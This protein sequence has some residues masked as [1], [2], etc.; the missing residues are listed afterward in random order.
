V[1]D[2]FLD[3][4]AGPKLLESI[5][6]VKSAGSKV[7][8]PAG[9]HPPKQLSVDG[10]LDFRDTSLSV[11]E[12]VVW[13]PTLRIRNLY[14]A[15]FTPEQNPLVRYLNDGLRV[16]APTT[17]F[18]RHRTHLKSNPSQPQNLAMVSFCA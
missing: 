7:S 1:K 10:Y 2:F 9:S 4:F 18:T 3:W 5:S 12:S 14:S 13:V 15:A 8:F 17:R 11:S 16:Y 6:R